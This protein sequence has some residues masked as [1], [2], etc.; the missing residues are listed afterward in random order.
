MAKIL[1]LE[2]DKTL[3]QGIHIT[4]EKSGH[5]IIQ[6]A[7]FFDGAAACANHDFD[8]FLLDINLPDGSGLDFCRKLRETSDGPI[9]F[10]TAKDTEEDMLS[11]FRAGCDDY[12]VKPFSPKEVITRIK[13]PQCP[14]KKASQKAGK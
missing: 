3:A 9:L 5:K 14:C 1:L 7:S 4:L 12:I 2:D 13:Y 10:L 6:A 8:L 11:G